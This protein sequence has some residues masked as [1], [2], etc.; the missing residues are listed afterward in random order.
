MKI[1]WDLKILWEWGPEE[2]KFCEILSHRVK[3]A[4]YAP[5]DFVAIFPMERLLQ[6]GIYFPTI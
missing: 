1:L 3:Y 4:M 5:G 6:A 2:P